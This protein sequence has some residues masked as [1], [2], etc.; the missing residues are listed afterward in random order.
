MTIPNSIGQHCIIIFNGVDWRGL[1]TLNFYIWFTSIV[2][3]V[4]L[5]SAC[6][7]N[8]YM[9]IYICMGKIHHYQATVKCKQQAFFLTAHYVYPVDFYF[10]CSEIANLLS[11]Y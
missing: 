5:P 7:V 9:Y 8:I 1:F 4:W 6:K 11:F 3:I 2:S 10:Y